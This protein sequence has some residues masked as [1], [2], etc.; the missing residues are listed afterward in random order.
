[1]EDYLKPQI[2][3]IDRQIEENRL[4]LGD[5]DLATLAEAE[6]A[7]LEELKTS[8][9][10]PR[11]DTG[12]ATASSSGIDASNAIVEIRAAAGGDEA[13]LFGGVLYRMYTR[14]ADTR[15]WRVEQISENAGGLGNIKEA[16]FKVS[17]A[18]A[19]GLLKFES[20]VHRVQ[21][22]PETES[23]GRIHTS[24]ATVAVDK[25]FHIEEKDIKMD[26]F[27]ASGH[28]GQNVQKVE[29]AVR[30]THTP[31][32]VIATCQTERSQ[33]QNREKALAILRARVYEQQRA[34]E[35]PE[36]AANRRLQVGTGDR[37]EKIR[38]YN[39][40]Q[41]RITDHRLGESFHNIQKILDG[42]LNPLLDSL[43][44]A[45]QEDSQG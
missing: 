37:S 38:T 16:V 29:T 18:G 35:V 25:D 42:D 8:L 14:F 39:Y 12:G 36:V 40:P 32:G 11:P 24:T 20:G 22:V 34:K 17:G 33:F 44:K 43:Q 31:T 30:L 41:D 45:A 19:Y 3:E 10:T 28:G 5:P 26:T 9:L 21:R 4:L 7:R 1:M 2:E 6:I 13:G 15:G 27:H 23:S